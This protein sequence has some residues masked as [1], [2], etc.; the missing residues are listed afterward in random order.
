MTGENARLLADAHVDVLYRM[1]EQGHAFYGP[2]KLQAG[3]ERLLEA[4]VATQVFA[5]YVSP[6]LPAEYQFELVVRQIDLFYEQVVRESVVRPVHNFLDLQGA[7]TNGELAGILSLEGGGCLRG[8][9]DLLR[10]LHRLGVRGIG[11]TWNHANELADG[12]REERG[13]GLTAA[14]L[15]VAMEA[16][17]LGMWVDL[18]HLADRGVSDLFKRTSGTL[19]ASHANC[20]SVHRHP[21]NLT[22]DVL[23]EL[24]HRKGW[25]GLVFEAT[26]VGADGAQ[27]VEHVL[28]HLDHA[29]KLGGENF[30]G[31]GSDFDGTSHPVL[32]LA[33][34]SDYPAFAQLLEDRYGAE[35]AEK[36]LFKNFEDFLERTL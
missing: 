2:S 25:L 27:S 9:T 21:R 29:L 8:R 7:R 5:L 16:G 1:Q 11:L 24:F 6:T 26:F 4:G 35:L 33:D 36:I 20:R 12:C 15:E 22:D 31:L 3:A 17:R 30:V 18:A 23:Q 19:M 10:V 13:G 14:G 34:A 32:G 28:A